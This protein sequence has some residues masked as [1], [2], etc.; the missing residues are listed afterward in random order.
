MHFPL[1]LFWLAFFDLCRAD[2]D[3]TFDASVPTFA[4]DYLSDGVER[5]DWVV[6][7]PPYKGA[8]KFVKAALTVAKHGVA[9]KLPLSFL[10]PC[11]NRGVWL[12]N[13]SPAVLIFLSRATY[14]PVHIAVGEFWGVWYK[15][16]A[17]DLLPRL[18]FCP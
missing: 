6:T 11:A 10:E 9:L 8:I 2:A 12:Q 5:P 15:A 3:T 17:R 16:E 7:S 18:I 1:S 4:R 13:N 14:T